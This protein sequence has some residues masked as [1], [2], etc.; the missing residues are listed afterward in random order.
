MGMRNWW[1]CLGDLLLCVCSK[2]LAEGLSLRDAWHFWRVSCD[3]MVICWRV[4]YSSKAFFSSSV[5][6]P[7]SWDLLISDFIFRDAA[8]S[9]SPQCSAMANLRSNQ[10]SSDATNRSWSLGESA[11]FDL[12]VTKIE[13]NFVGKEMLKPGLLCHVPFHITECISKGAGCF[14]DSSLCT[15]SPIGHWTMCRLKNETADRWLIRQKFN[16]LARFFQFLINQ[17]VSRSVDASRS[18]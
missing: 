15:L 4:P 12:C 9:C 3:E 7:G 8:T 10:R 6:A 11:A 14:G 18:R 16:S 1:W 2:A 17:L 5:S 13:L